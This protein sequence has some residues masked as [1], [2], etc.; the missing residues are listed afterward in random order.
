MS[1]TLK[2]GGDPV[3]TNTSGMN[4]STLAVWSLGIY[5]ILSQ[6]VTFRVCTLGKQCGWVGGALGTDVIGIRV[7]VEV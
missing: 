4:V 7:Y 3:I 1:T 5:V 2:A 6:A